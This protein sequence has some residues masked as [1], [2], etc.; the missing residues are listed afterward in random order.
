M[1]QKIFLDTD[2]ILDFALARE[3]FFQ[4]AQHLFTLIES[5]I[6]QGFTSSLIIANCYYIL[7]KF[8]SHKEAIQIIQNLI[9]LL[10][11]LPVHKTD[12]Q[13]SIKS[14]FKD[15]EDGIQASVAKENQIKILLTRNLKDYSKATLTILSPDEFLKIQI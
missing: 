10:N 2:V 12:L 5:N 9:Q 11:I 7:Q 6:L 4:N 1:K 14:N 13:N 8:Y 3:P 15:F